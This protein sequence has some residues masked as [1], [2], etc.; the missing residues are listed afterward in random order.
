MTRGGDQHFVRHLQQVGE[1]LLTSVEKT[2]DAFSIGDAHLL[3]ARALLM[4]GRVE[5]ART[6]AGEAEAAFRITGRAPS[7]ALA[8]YIDSVA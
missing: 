4:S 6:E 8:K 2:G 1:R 5:R 3:M 7:V